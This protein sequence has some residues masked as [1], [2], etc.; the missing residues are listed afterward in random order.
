MLAQPENRGR[1]VRSP[2]GAN[3]LECPET[4]VEGVGQDVH[5]GVVPCDELSI[6]P[7]LFDLLDHSGILQ[8]GRMGT[9]PRF[10]RHDAV[11]A[12]S[13]APPIRPRQPPGPPAT[14]RHS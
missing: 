11:S 4:I 14:R 9:T 1:P 10:V 12:W 6:H 2:V 5:L 3:T 8:P 7:Y 13:S